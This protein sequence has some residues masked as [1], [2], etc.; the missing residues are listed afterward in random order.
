MNVSRREA[1]LL[2]SAPVVAIIGGPG[3]A[4]TGK[5]DIAMHDNIFWSLIDRIKGSRNNDETTNLEPLIRAL[6]KLSPVEIA[7]FYETLALKTHALDTR[8][9]YNAFSS[10]PGL[11]D[12]FLYTRLSVVAQGRSVYENVLQNPSKFPARSANWLEGLLYVA[13]EA[14]MRSTGNEFPRNASVIIESFFNSSGW[15]K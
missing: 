6:S 15:K 3:T 9:H 12:T 1:L 14:Y 7:A 8:A 13:D 5:N 4:N 11:S 10:I 2:L